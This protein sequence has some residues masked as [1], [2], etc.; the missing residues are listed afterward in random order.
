MLSSSL[1]VEL[2]EG[3]RGFEVE[4]VGVEAFQEY[5]IAKR[6]DEESMVLQR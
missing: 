2:Q 4:G 3:Y 5:R 6:L 1:P